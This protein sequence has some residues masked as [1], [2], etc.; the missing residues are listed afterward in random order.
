MPSGRRRLRQ[1]R[2]T[3]HPPSRR[4]STSSV[5]IRTSSSRAWSGTRPGPRQRRRWNVPPAD[6]AARPIE[7]MLAIKAIPEFADVHPDDL[8][9]IADHAR[10]NTFRR[11]DTLYAGTQHPASSVHLV[12][13]GRVAEYRGGRLFVTHGPQRVLGGEDALARSASDVVAVAEEDTRTLAIERDQLRDVLED[14]F[15]VLSAALHGVAAA[16]LRLRRR[17][18]P[19]AGYEPPAAPA[20]GSVAVPEDLGAR[21]GF[22]WRQTWLRHA[23][24]RTLGQLAS[25]ATTATLAEA[26]PLWTVGDPAEDALIVVTGR[27]RCET[28]DGRQRF[29]AAGGTILGLEE[30]LA[31]DTRW[32]RAVVRTPGSAMRIGR[33]AVIDVLEDDPDS[34]LELL[35]ALAGIAS[36][37]R[38]QV[39]SGAGEHP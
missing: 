12:L 14:N 1:P 7:R 24:L 30:A 20:A 8:A 25:E 34:A 37:L 16:T 38:D 15:G 32:Y 21:V 4:S 39:A 29:E 17:I 2:S 6:E 27:V 28:D 33:A 35:A 9:V 23:R 10:V 31:M 22:L 19:S 36:C 5:A 26:E 18:V 11:G 13:E 3:R